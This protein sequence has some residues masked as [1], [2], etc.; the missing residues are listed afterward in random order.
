MT[1]GTV[2]GDGASGKF[3]ALIGINPA[4]PAIRGTTLSVNS[5]NDRPLM[6]AAIR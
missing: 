6:G 5:P 1:S 3:A 2:R 4:Q